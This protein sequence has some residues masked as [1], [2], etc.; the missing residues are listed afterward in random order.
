MARR[1]KLPCS[2]AARSDHALDRRCRG[3]LPHSEWL[4]DLQCLPL[5]LLT[6]PR[7]MTL[8][9]WLGRSIAWHLSAVWVL[10][11]DG[12][13]YLGYGIVS[14]HFRRDILPPWPKVIL[15][16]LNDALHF[17]LP[18]QLGYYNGVQRLLYMGVI[19]VICLSVVTGFSIWKPVQLGW[20]T[21][22]F[23][24]YPVARIIHLS[25]MFLILGFLIIHLTLVAI[26]PRTLVSMLAP[27]RRTRMALHEGAR[28][29]PQARHRAGERYRPG[30][31]SARPPALS[32]RR[33]FRGGAALLTGCDLSTHSGV[34]AALWAMLKFNDRVQQAAVQSEASGRNLPGQRDH[35]A[36]PLQRVLSGVAGSHRA[37]AVASRVSGL[38]SDKDAWN[39]E[40]LLALP[41]GKPDHA[42][43]LHRR[44]ESNRSVARR[45]AACLSPPHRR[46]FAGAL[47]RLQLLRRLRDEH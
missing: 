47:C 45:A 18:H 8:G 10:F 42:A 15:R 7:W 20:L 38:V 6:F 23:G 29:E 13:A 40:T 5:P 44:L 36:L 19:I 35:Q 3:H 32:D 17:R 11:A 27:L 24:G 28:D 16:D 25:M 33:R 37:T 41:P 4:G 43:H 12:L 1:Q 31:G 34:D 22:L 39:L 26:V 9:G 46:G 14:G 30:T 2:S 21:D